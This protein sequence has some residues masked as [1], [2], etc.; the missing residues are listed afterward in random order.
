MEE[1]VLQIW[2]ADSGQYGG[3]ILRGGV[4]DGRVA[5]CTSKADVECQA[6]EAGIEFDRVEVLDAMPPV[7]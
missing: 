1:V 2:K 4:E 7:Q 5:G 6:I 3:R